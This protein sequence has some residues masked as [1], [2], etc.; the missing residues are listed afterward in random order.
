[1][2]VIH[3]FTDGVQ[4]N[5]SLHCRPDQYDIKYPSTC[6]DLDVVNELL[7]AV[8]DEDHDDDDDEHDHDMSPAHAPLVFRYPVT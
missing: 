8:L 6:D 7:E 3:V 1:M 5:Y 2:T 4:T